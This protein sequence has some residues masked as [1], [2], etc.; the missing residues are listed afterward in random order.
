M[1]Y[2]SI[3]KANLSLGLRL[4]ILYRLRKENPEKNF[5]PASAQAICPDMK[6]I[7]LEKVLISPFWLW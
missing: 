1:I 7:T 2:W 4:S 6:K 3:K 5:Y